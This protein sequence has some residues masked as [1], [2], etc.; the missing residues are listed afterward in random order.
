VE[1]REKIADLIYTSGWDYDNMGYST[2]AIKLANYMCQQTDCFHKTNQYNEEY[3]TFFQDI[4]TALYKQY[5]VRTLL[6]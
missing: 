6:H 4:L 2:Y 5:T 1:S 3:L